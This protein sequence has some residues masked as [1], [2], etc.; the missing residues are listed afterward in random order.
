MSKFELTEVGGEFGNLFHKLLLKR[1]PG[2]ELSRV[3][4]EG[5]ARCLSIAAF[6]AELSTG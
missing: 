1:A 3:V 2:V 5:E 4:S 6:F